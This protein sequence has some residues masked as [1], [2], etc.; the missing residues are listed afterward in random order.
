MLLE[1]SSSATIR[2]IPVIPDGRVVYVTAR[3]AGRVYTIELV[4]PS[5]GDDD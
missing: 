4:E 1:M 5:E 3:P 2:D